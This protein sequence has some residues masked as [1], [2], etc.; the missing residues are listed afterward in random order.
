MPK[1]KKTVRRQVAT[2]AAS[3]ARKYVNL[4]G[5]PA[6][7]PFSDGVL[8]GNTLYLAGRMGFDPTTGKPPDSP[9]DE[10]RILLDGVKAVISAAGMTMDDLAYVTVC[11]P[12]LTLWPGFNEVYRPYFSKDFPARAF[13]GGVQLLRG[14]RFELQAIAVKK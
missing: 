4:P 5:R 3:P 12:D 8:V 6:G 10:A 1:A 7:L 14:G 11:S 2:K 9:A 13:I